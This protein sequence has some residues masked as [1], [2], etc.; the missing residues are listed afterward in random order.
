M[1]SIMT[2]TVRTNAPA[3]IGIAISKTEVSASAN[4]VKREFSAD[5]SI[6]FCP[7]GVDAPTTVVVESFFAVICAIDVPFEEVCDEGGDGAALDRVSGDGAETG[8]GAN[9]GDG[10]D[11]GGGEL[12]GGGEVATSGEAEGGGCAHH[13][14]G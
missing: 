1:W 3:A 2:K 7:I 6:A 10:T 4:D 5:S 9:V 14:G 13:G 11:L 12:R 8:G